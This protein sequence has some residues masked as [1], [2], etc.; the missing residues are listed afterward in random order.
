M[1]KRRIGIIT[2]GVGLVAF[3]VWLILIH[4][5][6]VS[7]HSLSYLGPLLIIGFGVEIL[8]TRLDRHS[9]E[10]S[11]YSGFAIFFMVAVAVVSLSS[12]GVHSVQR[13][14]SQGISFEPSYLVSVHGKMPQN[15]INRIDVEVN[16]GDVTVEG[17]DGT[18]VTYD[19]ALRIAAASQSDAAQKL[20]NQWKVYTDGSTLIL[21]QSLQT[22]S[23][24][25]FNAT[26]RAHLDL[27]IPHSLISQI[28][29]RNGNITIQNMSAA[30]EARTWN[31]GL[32]FT[33]ITG[34]VTGHTTNGFCHA[35]HIAG[36]TSLGTT[37]G[38]VEITDIN[39]KLTATTTNGSVNI[40]SA[41]SGD[42][43][44]DTTNGSVDLTVPQPTNATIHAKTT[45]GSIGGSAN[46]QFSSGAHHH[47][48]V[49]FGAGTYD[50][51]VQTTLGSVTVTTNQA[52]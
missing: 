5:R 12:Y 4:F 37:N 41:V 23:L 24:N 48:S 43:Q 42:W 17:Y 1:K 18:S 25:N 46:W 31:G 9:G 16:T 10:R 38:Q 13:F 26:N 52:A 45:I 22:L 40:N 50:I 49:Q 27:K 19:G 14:V 44:V 20:H 32:T 35:S 6:L 8:L 7:W 3:G 36:E 28:D 47:A 15:Q 2:T 30:S 29:T 33:N 39:G 21:K 34:T 51:Q 11:H